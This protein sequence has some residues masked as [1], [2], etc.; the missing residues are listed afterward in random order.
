MKNAQK[1]RFGKAIST[2]VLT[3]GALF[4]LGGTLKIAVF[5]ETIAKD[6]GFSQTK[7]TKKT[8][9]KCV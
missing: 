7:N 1:G 3:N 9:K 6:S 2:V 4:F 5:G 8:N